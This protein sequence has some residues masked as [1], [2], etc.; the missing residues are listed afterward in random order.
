MASILH[1]IKDVLSGLPAVSPLCAALALRRPGRLPIFLA[2]TNRLYRGHAGL[3]VP[4]ITPWELLGFSGEVTLRVGENNIHAAQE[5]SFLMMQ[6]AAMLRPSRIF[7]IGTS[8]GR[9]TALLA[10]NTPATTQIFT[11]DL[12]PEMSVPTGASAVSKCCLAETTS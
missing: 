4:A 7:E 12:P 2:D 6:L 8:Q 11:L 9:T 10:M 3:R 1:R 5:A